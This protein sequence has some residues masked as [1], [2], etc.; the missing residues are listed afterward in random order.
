[1]PAIDGR[2]QVTPL[3]KHRPP[4]GGSL[5]LATGHWPLPEGGEA[6]QGL[7]DDRVWISAVPS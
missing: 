4:P 5:T 2:P 1:M 6:G 3:R 7:A